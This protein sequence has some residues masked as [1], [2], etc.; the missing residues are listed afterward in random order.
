MAAKSPT[1]TM[2]F[3]SARPAAKKP[4]TLARAERPNTAQIITNSLAF[5]IADAP[6]SPSA[7]PRSDRKT[8]SMRAQL[9]SKG[10]ITVKSPRVVVKS[11]ELS[12]S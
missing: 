5:V 4:T 1:G 10:L 3:D 7:E 12:P 2:I 6:R 9:T 11:I 8:M